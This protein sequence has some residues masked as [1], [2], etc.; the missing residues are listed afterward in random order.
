MLLPRHDVTNQLPKT[1]SQFHGHTPHAPRA[2]SWSLTFIPWKRACDML[3]GMLGRQSLFLFGEDED[4][5]K[6]EE[7]EEY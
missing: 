7:E 6:E 4:E 5:D 2:S 1:F 3:T